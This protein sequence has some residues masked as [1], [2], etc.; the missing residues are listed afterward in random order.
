MIDPT[1][2]KTK[3]TPSRGA[4]AAAALAGATGVILGAFGAHALQDSLAGRNMT[5]VWETAVAYQMWHAVALLALAVAP[6]PLR[7]A[8]T[9][10][11]LWC[12]GILL[13]S[14]S[15]YILALDG[16][17]WLGPVTPL[18]GLALIAGW[19]LLGISTVMGRKTAI[20]D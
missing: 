11:A 1:T 13:F 10:T 5:G 7:W 18:G 20:P 8:G 9:V 4:L 14:G 12:A 3:A 15:L 17:R 6:F 16:P 19:L 2:P